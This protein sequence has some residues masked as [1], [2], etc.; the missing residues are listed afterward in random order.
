MSKTEK[1][2]NNII[3]IYRQEGKLSVILEKEVNVMV[4]GR[5]VMDSPLLP[6]NL[7]N[8][9]TLKIQ[10]FPLW[11]YYIFSASSSKTAFHKDCLRIEA[12]C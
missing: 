6:T 7:E 12:C 9:L 4:S 8:C 10:H 2:S 11:W 3:V 1:Y 5:K